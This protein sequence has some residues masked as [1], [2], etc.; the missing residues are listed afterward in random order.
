VTKAANTDT[1]RACVLY[2][3]ARLEVREVQRPVPGPHEV[4]VRVSAV[5]LCG[6]DLHIFRGE[7]NYNSDGRGRPI[8][9]TK[10]PQI[11]GHEIAGIVEA[12]GARV[13]DLKEGDRVAIDQGLNCCSQHREPICEYCATGDSHQ[14]EFYAEHGI[15]GL[16]GGLAE[17][18]AVPA[19]NAIRLN[20]DLEP[21][22]AALT[23][24]VACVLHAM[25]AVGSS[26]GAR[27]KIE[28]GAEPC[29]RTALILG[30]GPAG[31]LFIQYLRNILQFPGLLLVSEP[32]AR[33]RE[34]AAAFGAETIDP[35]S[36]D[37]TQAVLD[38]THGQRVELLIE[39][40]GSGQ[41]FPI[42]PGLIR[43]QATVVLYSHG[44]AG[45]DLS[46][47]NSI[48]FKEP[49]FVSP[50]GGS[51]G[52][53]DD[54]RPEVYRRALR[55]IERG[56]IKV[57]EFISHRYRSLDSVKAAFETDFSAP[58]YTKGVVELG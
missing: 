22:Q 39:A 27:Y 6:T 1:M 2:N 33:K 46:V 24:P 57:A 58:D 35:S 55:L 21:A 29:V 49:V 25:N 44:H 41:V 30:A 32:N 53:D 47:L 4:L 28:V 54:G 19:V 51:G 17:Y 48:Q 20:R 10:H 18:I 23:E 3:V 34:L 56:E 26:K 5:G 11:P 13:T 9:L 42:I 7:A 37:L 16:P 14:C 43:K 50:V 36:D 12:T 31:L 52:F 45:V 38:R 8:P 40:S 15:T